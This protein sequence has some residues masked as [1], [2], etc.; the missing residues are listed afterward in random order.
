MIVINWFWNDQV[1][2][3][4]IRR[5]FFNCGSALSF[6]ALFAKDSAEPD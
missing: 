6:A 1:W 2:R 3:I 5:F 4:S